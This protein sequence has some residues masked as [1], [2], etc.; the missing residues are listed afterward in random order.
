M[1]DAWENTERHPFVIYADFETLLVKT[2][3]VKWKNTKIVHKHEAMSYGLIVKAS[4]DE[5][6]EL[7]G[8][9][10]IPTAP[11]IYRGSESRSDVARYFVDIVTDIPLKIEKLLKTNTTINMSVDDV[12]AHEAATHCNLCKIEFS[13]P[14]E[15][16]RRKRADHC[17]L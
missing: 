4:E 11:I 15:I 9:H 6:M 7:L 1:F 12:Q 14:S 8:E 3:E 17:H 13:P 5:L 2:D 10:N 16:L